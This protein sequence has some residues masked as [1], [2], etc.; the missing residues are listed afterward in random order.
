MRQIKFRAWR[1]DKKQWETGLVM[2]INDG[3]LI[4]NHNEDFEL[5]QFTHLLDK[6]GKEIY[7]G[8]V[9]LDVDAEMLGYV[10]WDEYRMRTKWKYTN[11]RQDQRKDFFITG[12]VTDEFRK[13]EVIGTI[14]ENPELLN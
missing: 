5:V 13:F 2:G 8:D 7:E 4:T 11:P 12:D 3:Q 6:T 9:L 1:N 14:C 10:Y